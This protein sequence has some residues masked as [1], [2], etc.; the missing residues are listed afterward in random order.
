MLT[1]YNAAHSTC[2]QK[3]RICLAEKGLAFEDIRMDLGKA[4]DFIGAWTRRSRAGRGCSARSTVWR[5]SLPR[6]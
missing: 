6:R 3:V 2:S 1:L 4:E 5:T